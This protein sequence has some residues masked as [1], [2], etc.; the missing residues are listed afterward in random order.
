MV[1][2][3]HITQD[4]EEWMIVRILVKSSGLESHCPVNRVDVPCKA[5]IKFAELERSVRSIPRLEVSEYDDIAFHVFTKWQDRTTVKPTY[6]SKCTQRTSWTEASGRTNIHRQNN[7]SGGCIPQ[8]TTKCM[9]DL[10]D[11]Q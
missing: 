8:D 4:T 10:G 2:E 1:Y 3:A 5:T 6:K 7:E 11:K 9:G